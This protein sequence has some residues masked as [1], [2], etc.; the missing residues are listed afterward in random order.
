MESVAVYACALPLISMRDNWLHLEVFVLQV[1]F[2]T[3]GKCFNFILIMT[4]WTLTD[5]NPF[6]KP[7]VFEAKEQARSPL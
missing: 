7:S 6:P 2:C 4:T 1:L 3:S 5:D